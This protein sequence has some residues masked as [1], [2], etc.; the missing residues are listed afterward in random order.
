MRCEATSAL[1]VGVLLMI[2]LLGF[3]VGPRQLLLWRVAMIALPFLTLAAA[4]PFMV[5]GYVLTDHSIEV[6]RLGWTTSLPARRPAF[7]DR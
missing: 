7:R 4:L 1:T 5:R 3:L 2:V 6:R